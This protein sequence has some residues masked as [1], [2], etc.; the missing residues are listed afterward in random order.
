M[1]QAYWVSVWAKRRQDE[2]VCAPEAY[3]IH[4]DFARYMD[5][6]EV[7]SAFLELNALFRT[8]YGDIALNPDAYGMPLDAKDDHRVFSQAFRNAGQAPYRP[9]I[10][11]YNLFACGEISDA[12]V[13]VSI[14]KYKAYKPLP[15]SSF[16]FS[17]LSDYGFMFEGL[18]NN[19]PLNTGI[20]I[21]YPGNPNLLR[22]FKQLAGKARNTDRLQDFLCCHF[23]LLQDGME[24]ADYGHG[25]D[26]VADR[27]TTAEKEFTYMLD[28]ALKAMG[29][30][31]KLY[32][33]IECHGV[34]YYHNEKDMNTK[35]PYTYRLITRGM[36]F[37]CADD[38]A[39]K[40]LLQLR[41]RNVNNCLEYLASCSDSVW[42]IFTKHSDKG[43]TKRHNN[44]CKHGIAYEIDG[45]Q[46]WRCACCHTP[47]SV[48]P[49]L[50]DITTYIELVALGEKR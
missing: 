21:T 15:K 3:K 50:A 9:F 10:L 36:D 22:L 20:I 23:R 7:S 44:T 47:F 1:N 40:M 34:A 18:K 27:V 5:E 13:K 33:G 38:E 43:C 48:K 6:Y 11:L 37:K 17:Q 49:K 28:K 35:K 2:V 16:L 41:I 12:A 8:V 26:D 25:A 42:Q 19:K 39:E 14:E 31:S 4:S 29:F 32:G 24:T 46:Y 45:E 30:V